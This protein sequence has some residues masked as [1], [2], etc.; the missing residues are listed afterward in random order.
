MFPY[1]ITFGLTC[2]LYVS[3]PSSRWK[4]ST[5]ILI[6]LLLTIF[7][8]LRHEV[9]GDWTVYLPYFLDSGSKTI[10]EILTSLDPGYGLVNW[11][12]SQYSWGIYGVNSVCALVFSSGL[13]ALCQSSR[14]PSLALCLSLPYLV[15]VV[16]MGY[17]R[18]AVALGLIMWGLVF[19][20]RSM[21]LAYICVIAVASTFHSTSIMMIALLLTS[22][23]GKTS[24][25]ILI[26]SIIVGVVAAG[27]FQTF[28]AARIDSYLYG[29][30]G[31][32]Y[33]SQGAAIRVLMNLW[34]G[35]LVVTSYRRLGLYGQRLGIA[36]SLTVLTI[37]CAIALILLPQQSTAVDRI[38]LYALP[39]QLLVLPSLPDSRLF[40]QSAKVWSYILLIYS[41]LVLFVWLS[42]AYHSFAWIPYKNFLLL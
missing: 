2:L 25:S 6:T 17:S 19:L 3:F 23:P 24:S 29:Y 16:A 1:Y 26:R 10:F 35:I 30:L 37:I 42:F 40:G 15:V 11:L 9:G 12:F 13:V 8:G 27:L 36:R 4:R 34:P 7:I 33:Q 28:L 14:R 39:L 32:T 22:T 21:V 20:Q 38:A 31:Q 41:F 18:Q 5:A